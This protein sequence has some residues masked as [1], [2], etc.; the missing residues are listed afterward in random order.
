MNANGQPLPSLSKEDIIENL[1]TC[2]L[3][4][5][6]LR[7]SHQTDYLNLKVLEEAKC[8]ACGVKSRSENFI[9]Q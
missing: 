5:S 9:L 7:F 6:K 1:E 2:C 3:C 4:G 8:V